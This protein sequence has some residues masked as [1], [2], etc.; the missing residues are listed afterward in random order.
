MVVPFNNKHDARGT[1]I[2][3]DKNADLL[4]PR[5][6]PAISTGIW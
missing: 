6:N 2:F 1:K 4:H 3:H 5:I